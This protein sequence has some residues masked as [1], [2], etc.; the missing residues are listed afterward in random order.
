MIACHIWDT[1]GAQAR[2]WRGGFVARPH[3]TPL[4]LAEVP[5]PDFIGRDMGELADQL[6]AGLTA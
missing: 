5:Q 3:N 6:I 1:I 2:G 4:T